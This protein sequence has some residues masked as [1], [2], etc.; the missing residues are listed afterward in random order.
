MKF[1][2]ETTKFV[3]LKTICNK[4]TKVSIDCVKPALT[5]Q[6]VPASVPAAPPYFYTFT[7][8]YFASCSG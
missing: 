8:I 3:T 4:P 6:E 2:I 7:Y 5:L 1:L